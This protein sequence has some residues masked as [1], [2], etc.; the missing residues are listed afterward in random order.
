M[1]TEEM[2]SLPIGTIVRSV[3]TKQVFEKVEDVSI[4]VYRF[5]FKRVMAKGNLSTVFTKFHGK[6]I[7]IY[8]VPP[9]YRATPRHEDIMGKIDTLC[10]SGNCLNCGE[11]HPFEV[12]E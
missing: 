8:D 9:T 5:Y 4:D 11:F 10:N 2:K 12:S 1:T 7:E 3:E 6:R